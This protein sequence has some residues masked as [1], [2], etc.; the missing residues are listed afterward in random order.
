MSE[1]D[2]IRAWKDPEYR[3][4]LSGPKLEQLPENPAGL[5]EL[6]DTVLIKVAGGGENQPHTTEA[7]MT[8][9]CNDDCNGFT[10]H[11]YC[12]VDCGGGSDTANTNC[13]QRYSCYPA[14]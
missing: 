5:I 14:C 1:F 6:P 11:T 13:G 4:S 7:A 8:T 3:A 2:I 10:D 12:Y 9:G